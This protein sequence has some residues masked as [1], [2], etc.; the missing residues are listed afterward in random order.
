MGNQASIGRQTPRGLHDPSAP[1]GVF[2]ANSEGRLVWVNQGASV[3][4]GYS[5]SELL[6][7]SLPQLV[8]SEDLLASPP[9][10][11]ELLTRGALVTERRVRR[12]DG[13]LVNA[14]VR[15]TLLPDGHVL[16]TAQLVPERDP[17]NPPPSVE[18]PVSSTESRLVLSTLGRVVLE[19]VSASGDRTE[20]LYAGKPLAIL[21]Y[22]V[23]APE[24][25]VSREHLIDLLWADQ[26]LDAA[27]HSV[28]Q[29]VWFLRQRLGEGSIS[30]QENEL[31]LRAPIEC[32][33]DAFLDAVQGV[34]LEEAIELYR[35]DFLPDFATPGGADLEQ[36]ADAER[37]RLRRLYV[38]LAESL[39]RDW[40][41]RG[42]TRKALALALRV[43]DADPRSE[44]GWRLVLEALLAADD[45]LAADIEARSLEW[46]LLKADR[47]PEPAT[48]ALL[49]RAHVAAVDLHVQ[50]PTRVL[51]AELIGREREFSTVLRAWDATRREAGGR[52][53]FVTGAA[54]LG[55]TR[56]LS[57]VHARLRASGGRTVLVRANPGE[58]AV[59][60]AL[61]SE[62]AAA[63]ARLPGAAAVSTASASALVALNPA[64]SSCYSAAPD[65]ATG[66]E[67]LRR[68]QLA[69]ADLTR[70][71][72]DE[73]PLAMLIDDVHWA[74][75]ESRQVLSHLLSR[76]FALP[77]LAVTSARP[78]PRGAVGQ[79][80][81]EPLTL[82]P[83]TVAD[84]AALLASLGH[85][86]HAPWAE[87]LPRDLNVAARGVPLLI[88]ETLQLLQEH[89]ALVLDEGVWTCTDEAHLAAEL[90]TGGALVR[91][92]QGLERGSRW[93]LVVLAVAGAP[94]RLDVLARI[95]GRD[96]S[97]VDADLHALELR[98]LASHDGLEWRPAHDEIA[99]RA[100]E[101]ASPGAL[102]AA[103]AGLGRHL[104]ATGRDDPGVL[105]RAGRHLANA[106]EDRELT[107]VLR[108]RLGLQRRHGERRSA[109]TIAT[110]LLGDAATPT[111]I[112]RL[113]RS[114][115]L[116]VRLGLVTPLRIAAVVVAV[117]G[118]AIGTTAA[119][120]HAKATPPD[121]WLVAIQ[122]LPDDS[123]SAVEIPLRREG[124]DHL[125]RLDALRLG[126]AVPAVAVRSDR[127]DATP[128]PDG[129][130][131]VYGRTMQDS[132]DIDLFETGA[133]GVER[134]LTASPGDDDH[135]S[136]SPDGRSLAFST[137]RWNANRFYDIAILDVATGTVRRLTFDNGS[138]NPHWSPDGLRIAF[139]HEERESAP[140][141]AGHKRSCWITVDGS[142]STCLDPAFRVIGW[143]DA[144]QVLVTMDTPNQALG[145]VDLSTGELHRLADGLN[146]SVEAS[147]DGF[148]I[149]CYC[150]RSGT[151]DKAL[152]LFPT[153]RPDLWR[154]L[155]HA[156]QPASLLVR[157]VTGTDRHPYIDQVEIIAPTDTLPLNTR[158]RLQARALDSQGSELPLDVVMW[159]S[160]D[161]SVARI[162]SNGVVT[163]LRPGVAT[164]QV[165]TGG[166]RQAVRQF[167]IVAATPRNVLQEN[168][169]EPLAA[170]WVLYG[171]PR[172]VI[173]TGPGTQ[174]AFWNRGDGWYESGA[175]SRETFEANRGLGAE[176]WWSTPVT[177]PR[178]QYL[179]MTLIP[180]SDSVAMAGWDHRNGSA[181]LRAPSCTFAFPIGDGVPKRPFVDLGAGPVSVP[182]WLLSGRWYRV[183]VQVFPDGRCGYAL[184]GKTLAVSERPTVP[185]SPAYRIVLHGNSLGNRMLVG[186]VE[187]W[188]GVRND[189]DW[190]AADRPATPPRAPPPPSS[191]PSALPT[192]SHQNAPSPRT[193]RPPR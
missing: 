5:P 2:V 94:L 96:G 101:A 66:V 57:D 79:V 109:R 157:F 137:T 37:S 89:G 148:W 54:G 93:L 42:R 3:L 151:T 167:T 129:T 107:R 111:R 121:T 185:L 88:L 192:E 95:S 138:A 105:H 71:V 103:N 91:R 8:P 50:R 134:R 4:T 61:A 74:D 146:G 33:R 60:W 122:Q 136:W 118:A 117:A 186:P 84:T 147:T 1:V 46:Q 9:R 120:L 81:G 170:G 27:R 23:C 176:A 183:R 175:Y 32:D 11:A 99:A 85:I 102:R 45:R 87:R 181:P 51:T 127:A 173:D 179:A 73:Q 113:V 104:A 82:E 77:V 162:D 161:T 39:V 78:G 21:V 150:I 47:R 133:D 159:R 97:A 125:D 165:S 108:R 135:A 191:H 115:P 25:R 20:L 49:D 190:L 160:I 70:A 31:E 145:R 188:S 30:A 187:A 34:R 164:M 169:A 189:V 80:S 144:E 112:S 68:R 69:I 154:P 83:L 123:L 119:I 110:E 130:A 98:G 163:P 152:Y 126:R 114:L 19:S 75:D 128:S 153:N 56:L 182:P 124:W 172:P 72:A 174:P 166:W 143:Y 155:A 41:A 58:R 184:N 171:D 116:P 178:Q 59:P 131:W 43:R 76:T 35:G 15:W 6:A 63:L 29:A 12:R 193:P 53:V 158:Y 22:L 52:A 67:A 24:R 65:Y 14:Q 28:R 64:L 10:L 90:A 18:M 92:I 26:D 156:P 141:A 44:G 13:T 168:W 16:G 17:A 38:R 100:L 106:D 132:G 180:N 36:W 140:D 7:L 149:S 139:S 177:G 48:R 142:H 40:L 55:K 62:L 86:P